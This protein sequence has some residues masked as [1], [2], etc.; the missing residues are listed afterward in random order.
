MP[1]LYC[2]SCTFQISCNSPFN[3]PLI[4]LLC[5]VSQQANSQAAQSSL[6]LAA[7]G[8]CRKYQ[9]SAPAAISACSQSQSG[10]TSKI[11]SL[12]TNN[13]LV[14]KALSSLGKLTAKGSSIKE[15]AA[16]GGVKQAATTAANYTCADVIS[17]TNQLQDL[18]EDNPASTQ[19][20]DV[21]VKLVNATLVATCSTTDLQVLSAATDKLNATDDLIASEPDDVQGVLEGM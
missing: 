7:Y 2:L 8:A 10:L 14:T 16:A 6:C 4:L 9:D 3:L 15:A 19:V 20:A 21:A 18:I 11:K 17:L 1:S 13:N 12:A 5:A